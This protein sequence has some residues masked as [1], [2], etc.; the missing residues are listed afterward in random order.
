VVF[1]DLNGLKETNDTY[2]H[3]AGDHLIIDAANFLIQEFGEENI[4]RI[5]GDEFVVIL[6]NIREA[7]FEEYE[8]RFCEDLRNHPE[9]NVSQ[10]FAWT[11]SSRN[12]EIAVDRA[13]KAMYQDKMEYYKRHN[14]RNR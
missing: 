12:V 2:G 13:D 5:G 14:R 11:E 8:R 7:R 1:V 9:I 3:D 10:G 4:F 6:N